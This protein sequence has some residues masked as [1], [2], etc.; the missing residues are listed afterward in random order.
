MAWQDY[1]YTNDKELL[2]KRYDV[3]KEKF[4]RGQ[5]GLD[6]Y[7]ETVGLVTNDG[8]IDW[9]I[10]E[11]D[12]FIEGKY[13]TPFN[14]IYYGV[15]QIMSHIAAV[16]EHTDDRKFYADRAAMIKKQMIHY[17]YDSE[18]GVYY[19][20]LDENLQVNQH[21][22]HHS[23]AYALCYG[24]YEDQ[25]MADE[26]S[27]F[28]A[29]DGKFIG[30]VY[31][32]YFMLKGLIDTGHSEDALKL[33]TNPDNRKDQKTFAAI[34]DNL[35]ATIAPEA[36]SNYYKPNLTLSHPWGATPGL[37]IVQGIMGIVPLK[38]GF[39]LFRLR[40]QPGQL[41]Q[42]AVTT[43]SSKGIIQAKFSAEQQQSKISVNV[44][45]N[46]KI[47]IEL[48]KGSQLIA[49]NDGEEDIQLGLEN[50]HVVLPSGNYVITYK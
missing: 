8:L 37:T 45:M 48:P 3:L 30:S 47:Q 20:S 25:K 2:E 36:W 12:G 29:N 11:R 38:P 23:S 10:R 27:Q 22:A 5:N 21:A 7:D 14:A 41:K 42:I 26:L 35:K 17:L 31:F 4:K 34:L 19:D 39:D 1:L 44:P 40:I 46:S 6:N 43:P 24:M 9:P 49:V 16:T 33:L 50:S 32:I 15:Y 28:V 13:N 18:R